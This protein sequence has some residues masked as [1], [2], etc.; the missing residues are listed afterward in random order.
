MVFYNIHC[1]YRHYKKE[2]IY[3][4]IRHKF[5]TYQE[6]ADAVGC[7][8]Q[9]IAKV[10]AK[11]IIELFNIDCQ[12]LPKAGLLPIEACEQYFDVTHPIQKRKEPFSPTVK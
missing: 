1:I 4:E 10:H 6:L 9:Q 12:R 8:Y 7:S 11:R 3:M 5:C 2:E